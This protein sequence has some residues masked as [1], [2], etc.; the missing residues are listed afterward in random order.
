[1]SHCIAMCPHLSHLPTVLLPDYYSFANDDYFAWTVVNFCRFSIFFITK[2]DCSQMENEKEP[3]SILNINQRT[4]S[5]LGQ[6]STRTRKNKTIFYKKFFF[7][8]F[9]LRRS[10][11]FAIPNYSA[12]QCLMV[13]TTG[14]A[15]SIH[16]R[17]K[18]LVKNDRRNSFEYNYLYRDCHRENYKIVNT[19]CPKELRGR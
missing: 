17:T 12:S 1:M 9:T 10:S 18:S 6:S 14:I 15:V 3:R 19:K 5:V 11:V 4:K 7:F 16:V 13:N 2:N 8:F